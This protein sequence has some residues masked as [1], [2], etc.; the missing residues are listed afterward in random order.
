[1][2]PIEELGRSLAE[3]RVTSRALVEECLERIADPAGEGP[4]AFL[5]VDAD[6]ARAAA[7][8]QDALRAHGV[9]LSP[10]AG[11][12][13]SVKD[14][15]DVSGQ[16]TRAGSLVLEDAPAEADAPAVARLRA[17]GMVIV[18][19]T[20]MTEF[21]F[22]GLGLNPH[23][24]TPSSPWDRATG[25][26]PGGSSAGAAVSVA[27]GMAAAAIGSDTGGSCRIPAHCCGIVGYKPSAWRVP[28]DGAYPLSF[29]LDSIG[30]FGRTVSC[31]ALVDAALAGDDITVPDAI[32]PRG[33]RLAVPR[34]LVLDGLDDT[35]AA[36]F[37]RT[38]DTLSAAGAVI[39]DVDCAEWG[40]LPS[41]NAKGGIPAAEAYALHAAR[42][43]TDG[44]RY[45]QRVRRRI[46]GGSRQ[47]A[48][49]YIDTLKARD[50]LIGL[51]EDRAAAFDAFVMPTVAVVAP[52]IA[53]LVADDALY[54]TANRLVLR[55]TSVGNF[56][57]GC[58]ISVPCHEDG[59]APVGFMLLAPNGH[60]RHI[61]A[62]ASGV[63][64]TLAAGGR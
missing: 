28:L 24:G 46:T 53:P 54:D 22:S 37:S 14:L 13:L 23:H 2:R 11:I 56:L 52:A 50:R 44:E 6:G 62:V 29:S 27:D 5:H 20:N 55:N 36:A 1:M 3:G 51:F 30:P 16:V 49:D 64:A 40:E 38:L 35:V 15:F 21:A 59:A 63:E 10:L 17:A 9:N 31:C 18:G 12:P 8:A 42:L 41:I 19:R 26:I 25:R 7:D 34:T 61:M 45:D 60:D 32:G 43:A 47:T 57:D 39:E 58:S 4:R 48:A 33:L